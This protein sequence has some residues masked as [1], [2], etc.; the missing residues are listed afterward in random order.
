MGLLQLSLQRVRFLQLSLQ[1]R[2][3][4]TMKISQLYVIS[5]NV[6]RVRISLLFEASFVL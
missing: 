5:L 4:Q 3:L 2:F 1:V 6:D